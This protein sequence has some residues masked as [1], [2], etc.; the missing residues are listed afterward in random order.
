[1]DVDARALDVLHHQER[2]AVRAGAPV[3]ERHDSRM[4]EAG[5]DLPLLPEAGDHRLGGHLA[6]DELEGH[7]LLEVIVV[8]HRSIDVAHAALA[9][10]VEQAIGAQAVAGHGLPLGRAGEQRVRL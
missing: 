6:P 2:P 3:E 1:V 4:L 5:Q 9:D 7:D 8:S 10:Q